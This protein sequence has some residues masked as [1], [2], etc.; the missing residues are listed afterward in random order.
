MTREKYLDIF[1]ATGVI[2]LCS[3]H[4]IL[5]SNALV[6]LR[7]ISTRFFNNT[8]KLEKVGR[9]VSVYQV[10]QEI[11]HVFLSKVGKDQF[12]SIFSVASKDVDPSIWT[13]CLVY[14]LRYLS[15]LCPSVTK[16]ALSMS[17]HFCFL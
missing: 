9:R 6:L 4:A 13:F 5:Q 17:S 3:P 10:I 12:P 16:L 7:Q 2:F 1:E 8:K 15:D 14:I 11:E